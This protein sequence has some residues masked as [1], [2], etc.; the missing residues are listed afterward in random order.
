MSRFGVVLLIFP[1]AAITGCDD[2]QMAGP[3]EYRDHPRFAR[4]LG[5]K[6]KLQAAIR[7]H[8]ADLF[9]PD[10]RHIRVPEDSGLREGG[11]Y[12]ADLRQVGDQVV[13]NRMVDPTGISVAVEG[14]YALYRKHCLHCHGVFGAGDGPTAA[15]LYPRPRD[16]RLGL[17]KFTSTNPINAKPSRDD[18]RKTINQGLHGTSMPGFEAIMTASQ[19]D[20]VIDYMSFLSMRGE[21]ERYLID[22]AV[23]AD[24]KDAESA[25]SADLVKD[26]LVKVT[27]SW[28]EAD[29][30]VLNPPA[31]RGE[32]TR[33]SILRGRDLYLAENPALPKVA[34]IGCHGPQARGNGSAF[35]DQEI[36]CDVVFRQYPFDTAVARLYRKS[37]EVK[38]SATPDL[39]GISKFLEENPPILAGLRKDHQ[40]LAEVPDRDFAELARNNPRGVA[41]AARKAVPELADPKF[42]AF[43]ADR[44]S[45]WTKGSLDDWGDPLRPANLVEG[46]YKGGSRPLDLYWRIAKGINGAKMPSH[47]GTLTDAQI[48]DVV[49]FV[50]ALPDEPGLL[51]EP[52]PAPVTSHAKGIASAR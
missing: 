14:G 41:E 38:T 44:L 27:S 18:L 11:L 34:C 24:D 4:E 23:L 49:N 36:F 12:L 8:L 45:V 28:K 32:V 5:E 10:V 31:R 19:V 15:F 7:K 2:S 6:P 13:P 17:F 1:L 33:A 26:L 43:L 51:P 30:Q 42:R 20:Q 47:A 22:E 21:T 25:L 48:W 3:I 9:G 29:T 39:D 37:T 40:I 16:Y 46:V 35:I 50:L 52:M